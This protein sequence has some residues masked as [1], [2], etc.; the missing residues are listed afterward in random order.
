MDLLFGIDSVA[1]EAAQN[2]RGKTIAVVGCGLENIYPEENRELF[3]SIIKNGGCIISEYEPETPVDMKNFPKRNRIVSGLA[4]GILVVE[5]GHRSGS[6]ITGRLGLEQGKKVFC[7]P[8]DIGISKGIGS[9]ELIRKGATLV[10]CPEDILK[11]YEKYTQEHEDID[12]ISKKD[13]GNKNDKG[14]PIEKRNQ[15]SINGTEESICVPKEYMNIYQFTS[16]TPQNIQYFVKKSGLKIAEATQ[17]LIMLELQGY[18][19]SLP[20]KLLY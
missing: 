6:T 20:R 16:Y 2:C 11:E 4:D 7:L 19:K 17:K 9:N 1:H 14:D 5:A 13:I 15:E 10:T 8:R 18:I 3:H 12:G